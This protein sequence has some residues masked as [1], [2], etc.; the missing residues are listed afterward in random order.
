[1][2]YTRDKKILQS[3]VKYK[4]IKGAYI[5]L[6]LLWKCQAPKMNYITPYLSTGMN[7][8]INQYVMSNEVAIFLQEVELTEALYPFKRTRAVSVYVRVSNAISVRVTE[9]FMGA[10]L[11]VPSAGLDLWN[12]GQVSL[13][14]APFTAPTFHSFTTSAGQSHAATQ[15]TKL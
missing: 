13:A 14:P 15:I 10:W 7:A 5:G 11:G 8:L 2:Y 12:N 3:L 6:H 1:M 9:G 4:H